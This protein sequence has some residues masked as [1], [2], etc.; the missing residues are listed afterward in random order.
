M[1]KSSL[2][3]GLLLTAAAFFSGCASTQSPAIQYAATVSPVSG[4]EISLEPTVTR[5]GFNSFLLTVSNTSDSDISVIWEKSSIQYKGKTFRLFVENQSVETLEMGELPQTI[6]SQKKMSRQIYSVDQ[7]DFSQNFVS[8]DLADSSADE[9]LDDTAP[10]YS[11]LPI[12]A[13]SVTISLCLKKA[14]GEET[15]TIAL[16]PLTA[17]SPAAAE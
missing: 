13:D 8:Y 17:A 14:Q 5:N 12:R 10:S 4:A 11:I 7:L 1:K 3:A 15:V 6:Q 16:A 9:L 2:F